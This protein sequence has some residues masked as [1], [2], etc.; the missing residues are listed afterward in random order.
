[1]GRRRPP[2]A[3]TKPA[4]RA[5]PSCYLLITEDRMIPPAA[6]RAMS[7]RAG[8]SVPA[9]AAVKGFNCRP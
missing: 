7:A 3:V 4:W 2:G 6:R 1:M 8:S 9:H 5:L